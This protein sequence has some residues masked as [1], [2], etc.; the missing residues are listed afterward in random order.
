MLCSCVGHRHCIMACAN[1]GSAVNGVRSRLNDSHRRSRSNGHSRHRA[2]AAAAGT[3]SNGHL[4]NGHLGNGHVSK[5]AL[6]GVQAA[7]S[8]R[9]RR[10]SSSSNDSAN[11]RLTERKTPRGNTNK[12]KKRKSGQKSSAAA[13]TSPSTAAGDHPAAQTSCADC[14]SDLTDSEVEVCQNCFGVRQR[15][16]VDDECCPYPFHFIKKKYLPLWMHEPEYIMSPRPKKKKDK[17]DMS[18]PAQE[19][20][21][22]DDE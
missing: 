20:V 16:Y 2:G 22:Q 8:G 9:E 14:N 12:S 10:A 4:S 15:K 7:A 3:A 18:D 13:T 11:A 19:D 17:T 1:G 21:A 5:E 6:N